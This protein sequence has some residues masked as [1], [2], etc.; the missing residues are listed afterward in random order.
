MIEVTL[1]TD[2]KVIIN[3]DQ[4]IEIS[5]L[6][7]ETMIRF[8]N[9]NRMRI[10]ESSAEIELP[11]YNGKYD[12]NAHELMSWLEA[13]LLPLRPMPT[14]D[15]LERLEINYDSNNPNLQIEQLLLT[16]TAIVD[17]D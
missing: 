15:S 16:T 3:S 14:L 12:A 9:D 11:N 5:T 2:D 1:M 13:E 7:P 17:I 6:G 8:A 10:K 4:I